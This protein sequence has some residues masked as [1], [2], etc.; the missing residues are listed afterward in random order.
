M[1]AECI[2]YN[3]VYSGH[4]NEFY[5]RSIQIFKFVGEITYTQKYRPFQVGSSLAL[6]RP[7][8]IM[9]A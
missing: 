2:T 5:F 1:S 8:L 3:L 6:T 9:P 4:G 7:V